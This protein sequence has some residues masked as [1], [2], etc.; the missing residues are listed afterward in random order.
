[1]LNHKNMLTSKQAA[2]EI[3]VAEV[4][5]RQ[6]IRRKKIKPCCKVGTCWL[7][8]RYQVEKKKQEFLSKKMLTD[9][10]ASDTN[11]AQL[12]ASQ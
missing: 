3:G 1:M 11:T 5:I 7:F 8:T 9:C 2:E 6:W 4:T 10:N 12:R